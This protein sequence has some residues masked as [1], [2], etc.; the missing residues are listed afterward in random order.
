MGVSTLSRFNNLS[1]P[2]AEEELLTC[3]ASPIWAQDVAAGRPYPDVATVIRA[4]GDALAD[5]PWPQV[6]L[7][8]AAHPRIGARPVGERRD[9]AWSRREQSGVGRDDERTLAALAEVNAAYEKRFGHVLLIF[10]SG[11]TGDN[12]LEIARTRLGNDEAIEHVVIREELAKIAAL[13]LERL[14]GAGE[15]VAR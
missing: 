11:K 15:A 1:A 6:A 10:A 7:A 2:A 5:L 4:A 14:L 12:M 13:R 9:A 8:L 3:C